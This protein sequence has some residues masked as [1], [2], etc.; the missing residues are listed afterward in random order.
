MSWAVCTRDR[1]G[2]R[3]SCG[4]HNGERPRFRAGVHCTAGSL[5]LGPRQSATT[6]GAPADQARV[7]LAVPPLASAALSGFV[8]NRG[9]RDGQSVTT[10]PKLSAWEAR[11]LERW[12]QF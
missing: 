6:A 8:A 9:E 11:V 10:M 7:G 3:S 12:L 5:N 1:L 2:Y 4:H